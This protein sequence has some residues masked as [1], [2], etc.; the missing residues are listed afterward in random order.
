MNIEKF[1]NIEEV[2]STK[3]VYLGQDVDKKTYDLINKGYIAVD[4]PGGPYFSNSSIPTNE[5]LMEFVIYDANNQILEQKDY[6]I[7]RYIPFAQFNNYLI[8]SSNPADTNQNNGGYLADVKTLIQEAGYTTGYFRVQINFVRNRVGSNRDYDKVF[9]QEISPSRQEI[10]LLPYVNKTAVTDPNLL[11]KLNDQYQTFADGKFEVDQTATDTNNYANFVKMSDPNAILLP[12]DQST[13]EGQ[14]LVEVQKEFGLSAESIMQSAVSGISTIDP[15]GNNPYYKSKQDVIDAFIT[16]FRLSLNKVLPKR[17]IINTA[18]YNTITATS[19]DTLTNTVQTIQNDVT[20][21]LPQ[22]QRN[23]LDPK[24]A[25]TQVLTVEQAP[26][27]VDNT[28]TTTTNTG[29]VI[30]TPSLYKYELADCYDNTIRIT[31]TTTT[32]KVYST[33]FIYNGKCYGLRTSII[34]TTYAYLAKDINL[35]ALQSFSSCAT[36]MDSMITNPP[37][38]TTFAFIIAPY[39]VSKTSDSAVITWMTNIAANGIVQGGG[40]PMVLTSDINAGGSGG[41]AISWTLTLSGLAGSTTYTPEVNVFSDAA[42]GPVQT[43]IKTLSFTTDASVPTIPNSG[44]TTTDYYKLYDCDTNTIIK[45]GY[46]T[47]QYQITD[48]LNIGGTCYTITAV[49]AINTSQNVNPINLDPYYTTVYTACLTC[50][51]SLG[52]TTST[53]TTTTTSNI[54]V[55]SGTVTSPTITSTTT[56][57]T[58]AV[59]GLTS[60]TQTTAG[61][62]TVGG[63]TYA[64]DGS[65]ISTSG[66]TTMN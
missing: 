11:N 34:S 36:C 61:S 22:I 52:G 10:R 54:T 51:N 3:E 1:K 21:G 38:A 43:L 14:F 58:N 45:Y 7:V 62:I 8:P 66:T 35:D 42:V 53:N 44:V 60:T 24:A 17:N 41:N 32:P 48:V 56:N 47:A 18:L 23:V 16:A 30:T 31:G 39:I 15:I 28:T 4:F 64:G 12:P 5:T 6:G 40:V 9:V 50:K 27:I 20:Y 63:I 19:L 57:Y 26:A 37:P 13:P 49:E 29:V 2:V 46:G 65:V 59:T 25:V 33:T 55:N